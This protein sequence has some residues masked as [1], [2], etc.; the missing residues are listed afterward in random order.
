MTTTERTHILGEVSGINKAIKVLN[1]ELQESNS[2]GE[3]NTL[4]KIIGELT[5]EGKVLLKEAETLTIKK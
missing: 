2:W 5:E 4:S 1:R 3:T